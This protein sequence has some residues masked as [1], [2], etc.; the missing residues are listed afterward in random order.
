MTSFFVARNDMGFDVGAEK[1]TRLLTQKIGG[2][3]GKIS[4][5][6]PVYQVEAYLGRCVDS[7][8]GQTVSDLDLILVDDGSPDGSGAIC[9]AYAQK[10]SRVH[11]IHQKNGGLSAARNTGI[12]FAFGNSDSDYLCFLDSDDYLSPRFLEEMLSAAEG[13]ACPVAACGE[14]KSGGEPLPEVA[15]PQFVRWEAMEYY[16]RESD[17][18]AAAACGK[19]Y[20]KDLFDGVRYPVG[21]LHEDEFTTYKVLYAAGAVAETQAPLY[22]YFQNT[23]GITGSSWKPGR[24]DALEAFREQAAFARERGEAGLLQKAALSLIYG[25]YD[26]LREADRPYRRALRRYLRRGLAL[27]RESGCFPR[28]RKVLW[29]YEAAWPAKP[30]W[31][32]VGKMRNE[33]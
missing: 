1:T 17:V 22:A 6:V 29:A 16:C 5:I 10:D 11:V 3:M 28:T 30:L 12:D 27:G 23:Q 8:L 19:I 7:V 4:V 26:Q 21:K 18:A 24:M 15:H 31:W 14:I 20:R 32:L 13:L 2:S 25:A 33:R 9:D